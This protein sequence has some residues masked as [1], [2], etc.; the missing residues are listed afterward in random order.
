[1]SAGGISARGRAAAERIM[2]DTCTVVRLAAKPTLNTETGRNE[3][4]E[5]VIYTGKCRVKAERGT[6]VGDVGAGETATSRV[7][8]IVS[9]PVTV[10][11]IKAGDRVRLG[12]SS[13]DAQ[14][15]ATLMVRAVQTG[16]F[17]TARRLICEVL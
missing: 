16:T 8:P 3:Y 9:V 5:T 2:T 14:D 4:A 10:T 13:D 15:N 1:M 17:I 7:T 6:S 12:D 11:G